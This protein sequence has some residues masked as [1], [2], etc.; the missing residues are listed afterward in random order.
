MAGYIQTN[1]PVQFIAAGAAATYSVS[2]SDTGKIHFIPI[3]GGAGVNTLGI[4]LPVLQAGLH[5]RLKAQGILASAVTI[6]PNTA[7]NI[8][9]G[10]LLLNNGGG[11]PLVTGMIAKTGTANVQLTAT[12]AS[13]DFIELYCDGT[14]WHAFGSSRVAAGLA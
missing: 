7:A 10:T 3:L 8:F 11:P 14:L 6:A 12:A 2:T 9:V 5:Y 1:Q 13:G 4:T